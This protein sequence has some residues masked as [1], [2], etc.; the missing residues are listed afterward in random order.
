MFDDLTIFTCNYNTD[1]LV[2]MLI[3][4]LYKNMPFYDG[5][6]LIFNNSNVNSLNINTSSVTTINN[7]TQSILNFDNIFSQYKIHSEWINHPHKFVSARHCCTIDYVIKNLIKTKYMLLIDSDILFKKSFLP[8]YQKLQNYNTIGMVETN[9]IV[10]PHRIYPYF[11][12][13][14]VDFVKNH[15][16][17]YFDPYR[18]R[19]LTT[20]PYD[21]GASFYIDMNKEKHKFLN[22]ILDNYVEHMGSA[23]FDFRKNPYLWLWKNKE[24][25]NY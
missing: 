15:N 6:I 14:D 22:I 16:V 3:K 21:T 10:K 12:F 24:L 23:S 13:I 20:I 5:K 17:N 7:T 19:T 9:S 4:S 8:L 1:I 18:M 2:T 25:F 11:C